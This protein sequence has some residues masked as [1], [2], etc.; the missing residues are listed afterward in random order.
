MNLLKQIFYL[1]IFSFSIVYPQGTGLLFKS[2]KID[3]GL[4]QSSV[5]CLQQ[6][7]TGYIWF[8]TADGLN[9]YD[10]YN[11]TIFKN[12]HN[13]YN[14]ITDNTITSLFEDQAGNLWAGVLGG[15]LNLF[16]NKLNNFT[17]FDLKKYVDKSILNAPIEIVDYPISNFSRTTNT[18][19]I[20][21]VEDKNQSLWVGTW[22]I[23]LFRLKYDQN[24]NFLKVDRINTELDHLLHKITDIIVDKDLIWI[25]TLGNGLFCYNTKN[26]SIFNINSQN[27]AI[28]SN[29]ILTLHINN[30]N[31]L[32]ISPYLY[33]LQYIN[34]TNNNYYL[35]NNINIP[36]TTKPFVSIMS[37]AEDKFGNIWIGSFG[38][39]LFRLKNWDF[40]TIQN[41][42]HIKGDKSSLPS[43]EVIALLVDKTNILWIG[44][45]LSK[46]ATQVISLNNKFDLISRESF[47]NISLNDDTVWSIFE[48][49]EELLYV[50][51][52]RGGLNIIDKKRNTIKFLTKDNSSLS[53]NNIRAINKDKYG[54]LWI[55]TFSGGL[56]IIENKTGKIINYKSINKDFYS[57]PSNQI[58][59]IEFDA[60]TICYLV[61]YGGGVTKCKINKNSIYSLKFEDLLDNNKDLLKDKRVYSFS[62][63]SNN[64]YLIGTFGGGLTYYNSYTNKVVNYKSNPK[65]NSTISENRILSI[66][67]SSLNDIWIGTFGGGL[68][69]FD[70]LTGKF[71][72]YIKSTGVDI[73]V[74]YGILEDEINN[75][76]LSTDNGI[77]KFNP[78]TYRAATYDINDGLQ[79]LEFSGNAY[80][81][82]K[83]GKMYFGGV[84][85]LNYFHPHYIKENKFI[86]NIEIVN[87][88]ILGNPINFG[89]KK[90]TLEYDQNYISIEFASL[91]FTNP[92]KNKYKFILEN[93]TKNWIYTDAKNRIAT[94]TNLSPGEYIFRVSGT[95]SDGYWNKKGTYLK[96][97]ILAPFWKTWWFISLLVL[98]AIFL[99]YITFYIRFK[100][101]LA[102]ER[103]KAKLA[104]DLHDNIGSSLTEIS[105][106]S[107][108]AAARSGKGDPEIFSLL[109]KIS[110]T[111]RN[112]IDSMSDIVWVV[113]PSKDTLHD[114]IVRLRD[115]YGDIYS[116]KG[117]SFITQNVDKIKDIKLSMEFKQNL[118]LIFKETLNNALKH[119]KCTKIF[120]DVNYKNN[121]LYFSISDNGIGF[122]ISE[123]SLGNGL[124]N[125]QKRAKLIDGRINIKSDINKGTE[126]TFIGK[127][128]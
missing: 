7:K 120:L 27:S 80:F 109:N 84:S 9:K 53:D 94:F 21:I 45:H 70:V 34:L 40:F 10:G 36:K 99:L 61:C 16:N 26:N 121:Y 85:G 92:A 43:D 39:G 37:I 47:G 89:N 50:G 20:S 48:D 31:K 24:S 96:I 14:S 105:I 88:K 54:N 76:W 103:L 63:I 46:G 123:N 114:L 128:K 97:T 25:A 119:S 104:A 15:E 32:F 78:S 44:H 22:G 113:N 12:D 83:S 74:V 95:N 82:T 86:P 3:E 52:F 6:D 30:E 13:D 1:L 108:L 64:E 77:I 59:R 73:A 75:L 79:A 91:D 23:G 112:V 2:L 87:V 17:N 101:I 28:L 81:K 60:D 118:Y 107:E 72:R 66:Y 115:S 98:L 49:D 69:K 71:T 116:Y 18:A 57:L 8:G 33:P 124:F 93:F 126:V 65:D 110:D 106:L 35:I 19:I 5:I 127:I 11:L 102:V 58:L 41:Y 42:Y 29:N 100:S 122:T 125:L 62:K 55:G 111:A 4:S 67:K 38:N 56:N 90:I 68:N 117:I 51:T